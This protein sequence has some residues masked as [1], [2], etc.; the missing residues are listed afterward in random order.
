MVLQ[1][2]YQ[3]ARQDLINEHPTGR[4]PPSITDTRVAWL[5]SPLY[6]ASVGIFSLIGNVA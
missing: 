1:I 6:M 5:S 2:V 3:N 4:N